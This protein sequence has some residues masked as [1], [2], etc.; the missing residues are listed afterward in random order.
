MSGAYV[1]DA[2]GKPLLC[3]MRLGRVSDESVEE[4]AG[5]AI[6]ERVVLDPQAASPT[7]AKI[8]KVVG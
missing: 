6:G 2:A 7:F 3:Q 5:V 4:L 8:S 1:L